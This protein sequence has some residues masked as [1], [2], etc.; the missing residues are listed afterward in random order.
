MQDKVLCYSARILKL[1]CKDNQ[2]FKVMALKSWNVKNKHGFGDNFDL[3]T[4]LMA[5]SMPSIVF[6][7]V[8]V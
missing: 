5:R 7:K 6:K 4:I 8:L 3:V 1:Y 2:F